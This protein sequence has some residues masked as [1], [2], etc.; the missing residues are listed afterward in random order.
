MK[1]ALAILLTL[2]M[3]FTVV[4][5]NVFAAENLPTIEIVSQEVEEDAGTATIA[6]KLTNFTTVAG[7]DLIVVSDSENVKFT[8][9]KTSDLIQEGDYKVADDGSNVHIVDLTGDVVD[10]TI[11]LVVVV[12]GPAKI[13]ATAQLAK[14]GKTLLDAETEFD[15]VD[16][17]I[18][19]AET[20]TIIPGEVKDEDIAGAEG[21]EVTITA[22]EGYFI[23][24]G[25]VY[26]KN[27][28][29]SYNY[30]QKED[31]GTFVVKEAVQYNMFEI[32]K[33]GFRTFG[34]SDAALKS[35][36]E[37]IMFGNYSNA[38]N[39]ASEHGTLLF[40]GQWTE[41]LEYYK[42]K[43]FTAEELIGL[44]YERYN[45]VA[46]AA[47][48]DFD[49]VT[50]WANNRTISIDVYKKVQ[51]NWMWKDTQNGVL[52]YALRVSQMGNEEYTAVA[53]RVVEDAVTFS[54]KIK[55]VDYKG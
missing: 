50:M 29:G 36:T 35:G 54:D 39:T 20:E 37:A 26:T 33:S 42:A 5:A 4:S 45:S 1:K 34:I 15:I 22:N 11:E 43:G 47:T 14:D 24:Y 23:P 17:E 51:T 25:S 49:A 46:A 30:F 44:I 10:A 52:E 32:P 53:Y 55:S 38:L 12:T 7:M 27:A 19:I 13:T 48:E 2:A 18:T 31:N 21:G 6:V 8:A 28:N 3:L 16:G 40:A 9:V 41:Y